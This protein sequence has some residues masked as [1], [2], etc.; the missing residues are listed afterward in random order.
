M[1]ELVNNNSNLTSSISELAATN[2]RLTK[3]VESLSQEVNKY[4]KGGQE[5]NGRG[6]N[7]AKYCTNCKR[8]TWHE[9]YE[10]FDLENNAHKRYP[11]WKSCVKWRCGETRVE[12]ATN[13]NNNINRSNLKLPSCSSTLMNINLQ[14]NQ[15]SPHKNKIADKW[16]R[17]LANRAAIKNPKKGVK[18]W[19]QELVGFTWPQRPLRSKLISIA[20]LFK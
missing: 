13:V 1:D 19:I 20:L 9:P 2:T 6:E 3:E 18:L 11:R 5:I 16:R 7:T 15:L 14:I 12:V 17:K 4:N 8:E 10:C